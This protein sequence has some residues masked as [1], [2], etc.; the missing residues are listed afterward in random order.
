M[1]ERSGTGTGAIAAH[2]VRTEAQTDGERA[3]AA[4]AEAQ[5]GE[6][7][8]SRVGFHACTPRHACQARHREQLLRAVCFSPCQPIPASCSA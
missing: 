8:G 5:G 7:T 6:R 1:Q 2:I 4:G 3:D